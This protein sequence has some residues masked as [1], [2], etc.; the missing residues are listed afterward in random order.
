MKDF[1]TLDGRLGE[2]G[3]QI[4]RT[5]LSLSMCLGRPFRIEQLRAN[6]RPPGLRPQHLTAVLASAQIS[7]AAVEGAELGS[8][9]V[10][11]RPGPVRPGAYRFDLG[12]AG[13]TCLVAETLLPALGTA[14]APSILELVGGTHNPLAPSFEFLDQALLPLLRRMGLGV[15]A[16]LERPGFYPRGGGVV[17]LSISPARPLRPIHLERRG[18]LWSRRVE[19]LLSRLPRHIAERE[20]ALLARELGLP[21]EALAVREVDALG[22][23]NAL[24]LVLQSREITEVVAG[25]G[26]RGVPAE[27]VASALVGEAR[28]Y[29]A[30]EVPVGIHLADQLLAPLALAGGG[31][32]VTLEPS[33]HTRTNLAVIQQFL[34]LEAVVE[35]LGAGRWRIRLSAPRGASWGLLRRGL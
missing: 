31:S 1:L 2:G 21:G 23:G 3:G 7:G 10:D 25:I 30:T 15:Q 11:F 13:S 17:R 6:R 28:A 35:P 27:R 14:S 33:L 26:Q 9:S 22:P 18:E 12:T 20:L 8:G 32:F 24:T 5:A 16:A 34:D 4:L 29:L 19:A